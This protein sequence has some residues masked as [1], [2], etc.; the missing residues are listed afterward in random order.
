MT[1]VNS[2]DLG[3]IDMVLT[4]L[5]AEF[6]ACVL[7]LQKITPQAKS[8]KYKFPDMVL[9]PIGDKKWQPSDHP[10][11]FFRLPGFSPCRGQE[12]RRIQGL[13]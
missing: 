1:L 11:L 2:T 4:N 13:D 6:V 3:L 12:E 10:G 9:P 8:G 5:N 7:L